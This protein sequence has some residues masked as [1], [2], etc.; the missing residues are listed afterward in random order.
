MKAARD[1]RR[2]DPFAGT[3]EDLQRRHVV[4]AQDGEALIVGVGADADLPLV[5]R[6]VLARVVQ[7]AHVRHGLAEQRREMVL[8]EFQRQ[9]EGGEDPAPERPHRRMVVE[10]RLLE[11]RQPL[12][13]LVR[14][15]AEHAGGDVGIVLGQV[16]G[17]V[18]ALVQVAPR[19]GIG[20]LAQKPGVAAQ[21]GRVGDVD[22]ELAVQRQVEEPV[23]RREG[24]LDHRG[25]DA[26]VARR[27]RSRPG[28]RHRAPRH[29]PPRAPP[30]PARTW[31][32]SRPR[33]F[34]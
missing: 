23:C 17:E 21:I 9:G 3:V 15:V 32:R 12:R 25:I 33:G 11:A 19:G 26:M 5:D 16:Q 22:R 20:V 2:L 29:R 8:V 4:G 34:R 24:A 7:D 13:P 30:G 14:P 6:P 1:R 31:A 10:Q 28:C 18:E 27:R